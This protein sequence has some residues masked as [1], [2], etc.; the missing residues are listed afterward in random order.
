MT[1][2][3]I[4]TVSLGNLQASEE[5]EHVLIARAKLKGVNVSVIP[6]CLAHHHPSPQAMQGTGQWVGTWLS[7]CEKQEKLRKAGPELVCLP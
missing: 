6:S 2:F 3:I 7:H 4:S 5:Y 1:L